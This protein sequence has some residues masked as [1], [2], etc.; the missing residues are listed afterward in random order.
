MMAASSSI[1]R[2]I[3]AHLCLLFFSMHYFLFYVS[4]VGVHGWAAAHVPTDT[5]YRIAPR[6]GL[7]GQLLCCSITTITAI[8]SRLCLRQKGY[9]LC[10]I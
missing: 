9:N 6:H 1:A 5:A 4:L 8:T 3:S 2:D 10:M 7:V